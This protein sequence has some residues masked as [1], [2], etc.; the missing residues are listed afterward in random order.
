M[1]KSESTNL[2]TVKKLSLHRTNRELQEFVPSN[3][4]PGPGTNWIGALVIANAVAFSSS[5]LEMFVRRS[6][7]TSHKKFL[8]NDHSPSPFVRNCPI[9]L[10]GGLINALFCHSIR[11]PFSV[12]LIGHGSQ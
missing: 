12:G 3:G 2:C 6:A 7:V 5:A 10:Y 9:L 11:K 8:S 1:S 4:L